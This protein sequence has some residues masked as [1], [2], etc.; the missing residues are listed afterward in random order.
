MDAQ[1]I[2]LMSTLITGFLG[3]GSLAVWRI[4]RIERHMEQSSK[5]AREDRH[6]IH[7]ELREQK[8]AIEGNRRAV[9]GL[10]QYLRGKGVI[11][12]H[13][14]MNSQDDIDGG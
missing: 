12:G 13:M 10:R 3:T 9:T 2:A 8:Q 14:I 11:N 6:H 5:E 4:S 7:A 1:L